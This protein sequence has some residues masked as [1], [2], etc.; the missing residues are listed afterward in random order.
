MIWVVSPVAIRDPSAEIAMAEMSERCAG[1]ASIVTVAAMLSPATVNRQTPESVATATDVA[2]AA[3]ADARF[4]SDAFATSFPLR[5]TTSEVPAA[6][7]KAS[8]PSAAPRSAFVSRDCSSVLVAAAAKTARSPVQSIMPVPHEAPPSTN[9]G[10][11]P[12]YGIASPVDGNASTRPS[13]FAATNVPSA[14]ARRALT[15]LSKPRTVRVA[16]PSTSMN[17]R[18]PARLI[19]T[20]PDGTQATPSCMS[21]TVFPI[22][23]EN[24]HD[25]SAVAQ[26]RTVLSALAVA[27]YV[28]S[29]DHARA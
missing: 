14:S 1:C 16:P 20:Q 5:K 12:V 11:F 18:S 29:V 15:D 2:A 8:S 27:R 23:A 17:V 7:T 28:P 3:I 13:K 22:V 6:A 25:P 10:S 26:H 19:A 21:R 24:L 9:D 4:G